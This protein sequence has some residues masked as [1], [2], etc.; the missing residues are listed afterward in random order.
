MH[1]LILAIAIMIGFPAARQFAGSILLGVFWLAVVAT[2]MATIG[3]MF[4]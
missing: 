1:L 4:G 2:V 3:S